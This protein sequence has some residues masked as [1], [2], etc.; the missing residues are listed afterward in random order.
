MFGRSKKMW[1]S[2]T[3]VKASYDAVIIGGGLHGLATAYFLARNH[4]I[5]RVAVI[6]R[7]Y[8][9]CGGAGRNTAIV[10]ANQRSQEN[11]KL[12]DEGLKLWPKLISELSGEF[13]SQCV[14]VAVDV[15]CGESGWEVCTH[16]GRYPSGRRAADWAAEA[17]DRG[18]GSRRPGR[19]RLPAP[20]TRDAR[21]RCTD[22]SSG[23][24]RRAAG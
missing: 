15:R 13:G 12:Y 14:V 19:A 22:G 6:E 8:I 16:G 17:A 18:A 1:R 21:P 10:R 11:V 3:T 7:R 5:T 4:G 23:T 9:G 2:P 20:A 24:S